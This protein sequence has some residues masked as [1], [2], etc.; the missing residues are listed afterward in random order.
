MNKSYLSLLLLVSMGSAFG[1]ESS[2]PNEPSTTQ[3]PR[4]YTNGS[5][6]R[7]Y[8]RMADDSNTAKINVKQF[9]YAID[10]ADRIVLT[11]SLA[12]APT[13]VHRK[14]FQETRQLKTP[15]RNFL[16]LTGEPGM[17]K[18][19]L[20]KAIGMI[21]TNKGGNI[22]FLTSGNILKK[23][24]NTTSDYLNELM[25]TIAASKEKSVIIIDELNK[26][27]ENHASEHTDS[28]Q[29]AGTLWTAMDGQ[30]K[31]PNF[32]FIATANETKK[33][34]PQLQDRFLID[35]VKITNPQ[36]KARIEQLKYHINKIENPKDTTI[37]E[38]YIKELAKKTANFSSRRIDQLC[39]LADGCAIDKELIKHSNNFDLVKPVVTKECFEEALKIIEAKLQDHT[40]FSPQMP[41]EERRHRE[42]LKQ[43]QEHF[44]K[45]YTY[46][47]YAG[48]GNLGV[49]AVRGTA[50]AGTYA[51]TLA[52]PYAKK[53]YNAAEEY[54]KNSTKKESDTGKNT[55]KDSKTEVSIDMDEQTKKQ[56]KNEVDKNTTDKAK[57]KATEEKTPTETAA[58]QKRGWWFW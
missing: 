37:N 51:A 4:Q 35:F 23:N 47:Q 44:E 46:T 10:D 14:I 53:G 56:D 18:S 11:Q 48:L 9:I 42:T 52:T 28:S 30:I 21:L 26:I 2:D 25:Q 40:D 31:N 39:D 19:T 24:R 34:S 36:E 17:G 27:L 7:L 22:Y 16:F 38:V 20:A 33:I 55:P 50:Y 6:S 49:S 8:S 12:S 29:T 1:M 41:D 3:T 57:L 45:N 58:P 54:Y 5:F 13:Q 43:N 15:R 32:F